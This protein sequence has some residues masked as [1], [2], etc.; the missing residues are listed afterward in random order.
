M[1][2]PARRRSP[3]EL[4]PD[5]AVSK[6]RQADP[7]ARGRRSPVHSVAGRPRWRPGKRDLR[8]TDR[9]APVARAGPAARRSPAPRQ[10]S[11]RRRSIG[12]SN[13]QSFLALP[14]GAQDG[15]G[16]RFPVRNRCNPPRRATDWR[17]PTN[18]FDFVEVDLVAGAV[19]ELG[20]LGRF[21]VGDGLGVLTGPAILPPLSA[22]T[23][24]LET[25]VLSSSCVLRGP[26]R[27]A[28]R[29]ALGAFAGTYS[30]SS[31]CLR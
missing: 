15:G 25:Q 9:I 18:L 7:P 14:V 22:T 12:R 20:G 4:E 24:A 10:A 11:S 29:G 3:A 2:R 8:Q 6:R 28:P 1:G 17:A 30:S 23:Q 5:Q 13:S 27:P 19:V 16:W 26:L 21:V 31:R